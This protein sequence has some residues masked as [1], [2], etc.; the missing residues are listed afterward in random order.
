M[1]NK[2]TRNASHSPSGPKAW[3]T[4]A[5]Q[6]SRHFLAWCKIGLGKMADLKTRVAL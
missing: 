2:S 3:V 6:R 5:S 1:A 4:L